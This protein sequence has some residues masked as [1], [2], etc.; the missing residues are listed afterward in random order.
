M[1]L[2]FSVSF[3]AIDELSVCAILDETAL[4]EAL[5]DEKIAGAACDVFIQEP[6][7]KL[8]RLTKFDNFVGTPHLGA[9]TDEALRRVGMAVVRGVI[10]RLDKESEQYR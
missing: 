9:N 1:S 3:V 10:E 7:T 2:L 4:Y 8:N 5:R 6:L